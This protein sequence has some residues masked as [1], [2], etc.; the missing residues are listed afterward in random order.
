MVPM[1]KHAAYIQYAFGEIEGHIGQLMRYPWMIEDAEV[2]RVLNF[3][4]LKNS[5]ILQLHTNKKK[6]LHNYIFDRIKKNVI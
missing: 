2:D 1:S 6:E 4:K 5:I 3:T